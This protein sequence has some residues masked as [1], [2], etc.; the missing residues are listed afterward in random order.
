MLINH[1]ICEKSEWVQITKQ[2][3]VTVAWY[4]AYQFE[5]TELVK[6]FIRVKETSLGFYITSGE[7]GG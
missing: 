4:K 1:G 7:D 3:S 6:E 2:S 5:T